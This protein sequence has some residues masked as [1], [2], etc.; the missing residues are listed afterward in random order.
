[1]N[2]DIEWNEPKIDIKTEKVEP[3]FQENNVKTEAFPIYDQDLE[4][5]NQSDPLLEPN[6]QEHIRIANFNPDKF[7][8]PICQKNFKNKYIL[9]SHISIVHIGEKSF[10]CETCGQNFNRKES[11]KKHVRYG[12]K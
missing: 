10:K 5:S 11:L 1:M 12:F 8:C 6:L 4:S 3:E 9:K 7:N 2:E